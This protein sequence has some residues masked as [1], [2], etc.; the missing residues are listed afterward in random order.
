M[1]KKPA[2]RDPSP[3]LRRVIEWATPDIRDMVFY[4]LVD[5]KLATYKSPEYGSTYPGPHGLEVG[6]PYEGV[7][8]Q[9]QAHPDHQL[10][11]VKRF[12]R[13]KLV[14]ATAHDENGME[15]WYYAA[16]RWE[17]GAY[18]IQY[19]EPLTTEDAYPTYSR[20]YF[21]P[22][23]ESE[24][25]LNA[26]DKGDE[27]PDKKHNP[28]FDGFVYA[29]GD[30]MRTE[31]K[32][33]D[34]HYVVVVRNFQLLCDKQM[35]AEDERYGRV[36]TV[37][38]YT[39]D[40]VSLPDMGDLYNGGYVIDAQSQQ[41][42]C[43]G[44]NKVVVS[45]VALPTQVNR[46]E[47]YHPEYCKTIKDTWLDL[48]ANTTL[49]EI[50]DAHPTQAGLIVIDSSSTSVG[51]SDIREFSITYAQMPTTPVTSE[52]EDDTWCKVYTTQWYDNT[53]TPLP[54]KGSLHTDGRY[55]VDAQAEDIACGD[56]RKYTVTTVAL[57]TPAVSSEELSRDYCRIITEQQFNLKENM[58]LLPTYGDAHPSEDGYQVIEAQM[59]DTGCGEIAKLTVSYASIPTEPRTE[60]MDDDQ[61]CRLSKDSF[62]DIASNYTLPEKGDAYKDS[63]HVIDAR[64]DAVGCGELMQFTITYASLP[65][66]VVM[67]EDLD[68]DY[69]LLKTE[70]CY[71]LKGSIGVLPV[72]GD[73]HPTEEGFIVVRASLED[74][75]CGEVSKKVVTYAQ[76]PTSP[77]TTERDDPE[78]CRVKV[79]EF[80]QLG[81]NY[82]LPEKATPYG[83]V[84]HYVIDASSEAVGCGDLYRFRVSYAEVPTNHVVVE[85]TDDEWCETITR[86]HYD[87]ATA[88]LTLKTPGTPYPADATFTLVDHRIEEFGCGALVKSIEVYAKLGVAKYDELDHPQYCKVSRKTWYDD[89]AISLPDVG[90]TYEAA[91][92]IKAQAMDV[93]CGSLRKYTVETITLPTTKLQRV[94]D[95]GTY[96]KLHTETWFDTSDAYDLPDRGDS[97]QGNIVVESSSEDVDCGG[98]TRF[99]VTTASIPPEKRIQR[100]TDNDQCLIHT[101]TFI[102]AGAYVLPAL[103]AA[104]PTIGGLKVVSTTQNPLGC[105]G[106]FEYQVVYATL[107][108]PEKRN[109]IE[110]E[111]WGRIDRYSRYEITDDLLPSLG[112]TYHNLT[113]VAAQ[114]EDVN[115]GSLRKYT[116][117]AV[118]LPT[119]KRITTSNDNTFCELITETWIDKEAD[120][121]SRGDKTDTLTVVDVTSKALNLGGL[122]EYS[123]TRAS[124]PNDKKVATRT[125]DDMCR[126]VTESFVDDD[127]YPVPALRST[128][129]TDPSL[130]VIN[131][132]E[133]PI[134]CG[135]IINYEIVYAVIP[136]PP[137]TSYEDSGEFC[138]LS[139]DTYYDDTGVVDVPEIGDA[140]GDGYVIDASSREVDCEGLRQYIVKYAAMPTPPVQRINNNQDYCETTTVS[141][142]DLASN[143]TDLP[144][145]GSSDVNGVVIDASLDDFGCG[146]IRKKTVVYA[147]LPT[148]KKTTTQSNPEFCTV[149]RDIWFELDGTVPERGSDYSGGKVINSVSE[150]VGCGGLTRMTVEYVTLPSEK[151]VTSNYDN[152]Y[153]KLTTETWVDLD[154]YTPPSRG[155]VATQGVVVDVKQEELGCGGM[156]RWAI[157][158]GQVPSE[159]R[160][161]SRLDNDQCRI[162]TETFIDTDAYTLP[163]LYATH[164]TDAELK[165]VNTQQSPLG[166][167]GIM[168]FQITYAVIPSPTR[169]SE[170]DDPNYCRVEVDTFYDIDGSQD[171]PE[172]GSAYGGGYVLDAKANDVNCEGLRR[173][174]VVY[175]PLPTPTMSSFRT[176]DEYCEIE[177]VSYFDLTTDIGDLP[178]LGD[179][180]GVGTVVGGSIEATACNKISKKT[181]QYAQ[182]PTIK[183]TAT[184][185][186]PEYCEVHTDMW[187]DNTTPSYSIGGDYDGKKVVGYKVTP[188]G[189][190]T[191]NRIEVSYVSVPTTLTKRINFDQEYCQ[192][193][194]HT[195]IDIADAGSVPR[196][197]DVYGTENVV[198]VSYQELSCG[199]LAKTVVTTADTPTDW[200]VNTTTHPD[201]CLVSEVSRYDDDTEILEPGDALVVPGA[202]GNFVIESAGRT[203]GCGNLTKKTYQV[204]AI[205]SERISTVADHELF[206]NVET[207]TWV[208]LASTATTYQRGEIDT[209]SSKH[210]IE[211]KSEPYACGAF[212]KM[213]LTVG[214]LPTELQ[215]GY[216]V[217]DVTGEQTPYTRK[218]IANTDV[219][220]Y[221]K[222]VDAEG[223]MVTIEPYGCGM[224]VVKETN[225]KPFDRLEW[226]T[227]TTYRFP[228][229]LDYIELY[230]WPLLD[231]GDEVYPQVKWRRSEYNGPC[232]TRIVEEWFK[233]PPA[234]ADILVMQTTSVMYSCPLF[235]I[236]TGM[237]LHGEATLKCNFGNGHPR[238]DF[239]VGSTWVVPATAHTDWPSTEFLAAWTVEPS[240]GGF[241]ARSVYITPPQL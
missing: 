220:T 157:T 53:T 5:T 106:I 96:C 150:P 146:E 98:L 160:I 62:Y 156:T 152:T 196:V 212:V 111:T 17:Q 237:C 190:G 227:I 109:E 241:I 92:V 165:V 14:F 21:I 46:D 174:E 116:I 84:S 139:V 137:R 183:K 20:S 89:D 161:E 75:G 140:Y 70:S 206:C 107:P 191:L 148:E 123:V 1:A 170:R 202:A 52:R 11:T 103:D 195:V 225:I 102:E 221:K 179:K 31:D 25:F 166:C 55:V 42:G 188:T 171:L 182:T 83:D 211:F 213:M 154:S 217:N 186:H 105:G 187:V 158:Y 56:V 6:N 130:K 177:E 136:T 194:S 108:S 32:H 199:N 132:T 234:Q 76:V 12:E 59:N 238:Y 162:Q 45:T 48:G 163:D 168:Q 49:P 50:G 81:A 231:G 82:S 40:E 104:H 64:A 27:D 222:D 204:A 10:A 232:K 144:A 61:W 101:E 218:L 24:E 145:V 233:D 4:I 72:F 219:D 175:A 30:L 138:R 134:G 201:L 41:T 39:M 68:N 26:L 88:N 71:D 78:W 37:S 93:K 8:D 3:K 15:R 149:E 141:N 100:R 209:A 18:N 43:Q 47:A 216:T 57:P 192:V 113:V 44:V 142:Y 77:T 99:S 118:S 169:T 35:V 66:P 127:E 193:T 133:T 172:L 197:G 214:S 235:T 60:L 153:C 122:Y 29:G 126:I 147:S 226:Y 94:K 185:D 236:N 87:L 9:G 63:Y 205:P 112:D 181:I 173:Y 207:F 120:L 125:D 110:S 180:N 215:Q 51:Q 54:A 228:A 85:A 131:V 121:P 184:T 74:V 135:G 129:P 114:S 143:L 229:V 7:V 34:S 189:C 2:F 124:L 198:D 117:D 91:H 203:I 22:R 90:T 36:D 200:V 151:I 155:D 19:R 159:K 224:S 178:A 230:A 97:V 67:K 119:A 80:F 208:D 223:L 69:C 176:S 65:T 33:L 128:H 38:S 16:D 79:D 13:H 23:S 73:E 115:C 239:A 210:I 240:R 28:A 58:G 164:A 167:G 95:D 86:S